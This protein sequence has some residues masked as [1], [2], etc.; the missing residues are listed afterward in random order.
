MTR[1]DEGGRYVR[2]ETQATWTDLGEKI[3]D[4]N[5]QLGKPFKA[6]GL[7]KSGPDRIEY[8]F[9]LDPNTPA[10]KNA[11][12]QLAVMWPVDAD[13]NGLNLGECVPHEEPRQKYLVME[14]QG[15][16]ENGLQWVQ[17]RDQAD[18]AGLKR[19]L[20]EVEIYHAFEG[21]KSDANRIE[22][23]CYVE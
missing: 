14:H 8:I 6:N 17:V 23:R 12:I 11:T 10:G 18:E 1:T 4:A 13:L 19:T 2:Y 7:K 16:L 21:F 15:S 20:R 3:G 5:R 22:M 9:D